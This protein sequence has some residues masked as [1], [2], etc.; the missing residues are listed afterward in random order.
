M[1]HLLYSI[2]LLFIC[3]LAS[4]ALQAQTMTPVEFNDQVATIKTELYAK[5]QA[6][7]AQYSK[8]NESA[9]FSTLAPYREDL[10]VYIDEQIAELKK[11]KDVKNSKAL[12][13]ALLDYLVYERKL[14]SESFKP[15]ESLNA[16]SNP[17]NK[18]AVLKT[19]MENAKLEATALEKVTTAQNAYAAANGFKIE[20]AQK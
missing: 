1:K 3:A 9:Q 7:G 11:M 18:E 12:Q 16:G 6:W 17:A 5:G 19:L 15:M 20:D 10:E 2:T 14:I 8:V 13:E 4:P